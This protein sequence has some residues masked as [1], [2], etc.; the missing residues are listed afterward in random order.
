VGAAHG[1]EKEKTPAPKG[2]NLKGN[3]KIKQELNKTNYGL[4]VIYL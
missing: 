4:D 2:L 3:N 1:K